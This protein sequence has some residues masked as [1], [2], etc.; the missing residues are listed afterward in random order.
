MLGE[1]HLPKTDDV[2]FA[3]QELASLFDKYDMEW[4]VKKVLAT[5]KK[6]SKSFLMKMDDVLN[7]SKDFPHLFNAIN[8]ISMIISIST[9]RKMDVWATNQTTEKELRAYPYFSTLCSAKTI[10]NVYD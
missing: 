8:S 10:T 9:V 4:A 3:C 5:D 1:K 6:M 2:S 7:K